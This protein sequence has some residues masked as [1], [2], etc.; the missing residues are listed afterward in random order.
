MNK[1]HNSPNITPSWLIIDLFDVDVQWMQHPPDQWNMH[2][3]Y[4]RLQELVNKIVCVNDCAERNVKN[5]SEYAEYSKD[6]QRRD[7]VVLV[8][9]FHREMVDLSNMTKEKLNRV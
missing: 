3:E 4:Q 1:H 5:V 9:N 7:R 8:T 2:R 6:S